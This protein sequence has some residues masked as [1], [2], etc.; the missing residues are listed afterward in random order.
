MICK[1][2]ASRERA[3][4]EIETLKSEGW[5]GFSEIRAY[6]EEVCPN[7]KATI[8]ALAHALLEEM[9]AHGGHFESPDTG[10]ILKQA[11]SD[12]WDESNATLKELLTNLINNETAP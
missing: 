9:S 5:E 1:G 2:W 10:L 7:P 4:K 12:D 8:R 6:E 3:Q 11:L